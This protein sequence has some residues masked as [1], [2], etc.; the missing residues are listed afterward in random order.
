MSA[1]LGTPAKGGTVQGVVICPKCQPTERDVFDIKAMDGLRRTASGRA[2][3]CMCKSQLTPGAVRTASASGSTTMVRAASQISVGTVVDDRSEAGTS[4]L[5]DIE[6]TGEESDL[7]AGDGVASGVAAGEKRKRK[8]TSPALEMEGEPRGGAIDELW[9]AVSGLRRWEENARSNIEKKKRIDLAAFV[10]LS[11]FIERACTRMEAREAYLV[12]RLEERS[13]LREVVA[14]EIKRVMER[15][16]SNIEERRPMEARQPSFAEVAR[17]RVAFPSLNARARPKENLVVVYPPGG[18]KEGPRDASVETKNRLVQLIKPREDNLQVRGIRMVG[19]GGVLVEAASGGDAGKIMDHQALK[20]SGFT[21]ER[22]RTVLPK[23]MIYDVPNEITEEEV[24]T[25]IITQNPSRR[26]E[27]DAA[28]RGL[29][30]VRKIAVRER[31]VEHWVLE[32]TPEVRDWLT[33]E[34]RIYIDWSSCRVKDYLSVTRCY[35]C[36]GYGHPSR[37]CKGKRTCG[38]CSGDHDRKDCEARNDAFPCPAC[39]KFGRN[40][41]HEVTDPNCPVFRRA[42]EDSVRRTDYGS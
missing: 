2:L 7:G 32:C 42:A 23:V 10:E 17:P 19:R 41:M 13:E 21:V 12:G 25:C 27:A 28:L 11:L 15:I 37:F 30:I 31:K 18:P 39:A 35:N 33:S 38:H 14:D 24:K 20:D 3:A 40:L 26:P 29:K 8:K 6:M 1:P 34:G 22:P 9:K 5:G 4:D 36:Q 16:E